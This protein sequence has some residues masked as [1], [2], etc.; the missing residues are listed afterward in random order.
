MTGFLLPHGYGSK[1]GTP[2]EP[3][4]IAGLKWMFIPPKMVLIGIGFF[5]HMNFAPAN[6]RILHVKLYVR[7]FAHVF[8]VSENISEHMTYVRIEGY[9]SV[10]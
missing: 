9:P 6:V 1:P 2:G 5:G 4:V 3:Q 10:I 8:C 7:I